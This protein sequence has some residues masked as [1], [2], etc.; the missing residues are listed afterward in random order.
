M[1]R[2]LHTGG[3]SMRNG[4]D[5]D[6]GGKITEEALG[7]LRNRIGKELRQ[8]PGGSTVATRDNITRWCWGIGDD[9]PLWLDEEYA[10]KTKWKNII[11]PPT[12]LHTFGQGDPVGYGLPGVHALWTEDKWEFFHPVYVND[13]ITYT[14]K[15][16][17][18]N[19]KPS[20]L[21]GR[22]VEQVTETIYRNQKGNVVA[23]YKMVHRRFERRA[24]KERGKESLL[25][26][27]YY[28]EEE[29]KGIDEMYEKEEVRGSNPRLWEDVQEGDEMP[30]MVRGPLTV[31][32]MV[33][34]AR[35]GYPSLFFRAF[36]MA[37]KYRKKHPQALTL[38][39]YGVP[40]AV[41][42]LHFTPEWARR[43]G[44]YNAYDLGWSRVALS[45]NFFT[46]WQGDNGF[47][48]KLHVQIRR[49]KYVGDV[50]WFSGR[51]TKKYISNGEHLVDCE[52]WAENQRKEINTKGWAT[53]HLPSK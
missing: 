23:N 38:N 34:F 32:D 4:D 24:S 16:V 2:D 27:R 3:G 47:L 25:Q 8:Q 26:S 50:T 28:T 14:G 30:R 40:E 29:I 10:K 22:T 7:E 5:K 12:F 36:K 20:E 17:E 35:G 48:K 11:A 31:T 46:N 43:I 1:H 45:G 33:A 39:E 19:E 53:I 52:F 49:P 44:L 18:V 6:I 15:L 13:V 42:R 37:Y 51:V 21:A 41:N 9:N